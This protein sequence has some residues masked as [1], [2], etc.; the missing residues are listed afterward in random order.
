MNWT[1]ATVPGLRL[2]TK[3]IYPKST[4]SHFTV[5]NAVA[6]T[7]DDGFCGVDNPIKCK[8]NTVL[9]LLSPFA[10]VSISNK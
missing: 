9:R 2:L 8:L 4:I 7:I 3:F 6:F 1:I 5:E 10:L